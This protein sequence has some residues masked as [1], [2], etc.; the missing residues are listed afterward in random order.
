M[1]GSMNSF[2]PILTLMDFSP[3]MS[4]IS[5]MDV[6]HSRRYS[7]MK[8]LK[9]IRIAGALTHHVGRNSGKWPA[10]GCGTCGCRW[11]RRCRELSYV[12][13]SGLP[14]KKL[15]PFSWLRK[16]R[17]RSMD[18]GSGQQRTDEPQDA[19]ELMPSPCRKMGNTAVQR[20]QACGGAKC[21]KRMRLPN[22]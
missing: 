19:S 14:R 16:T 5:I 4:W 18:R 13:W 21:V 1:S 20:E 22:G 17:L 9:K 11:E 15:L 8:M 10:S 6:G 3:K 12:R 7:L 2:S